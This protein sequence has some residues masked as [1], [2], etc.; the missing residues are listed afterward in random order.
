VVFEQETLFYFLKI[1]RLPILRYR[2]ETR[3][4]GVEVFA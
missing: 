2:D 1:W 3:T 4:D